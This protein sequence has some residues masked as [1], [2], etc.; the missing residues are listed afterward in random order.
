MNENPQ[1]GSDPNIHFNLGVDQL[2]SDS[3]ITDMHD[4]WLATAGQTPI[5]HVEASVHMPEGDFGALRDPRQLPG[6]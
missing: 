4:P 5:E 3:E 2:A 6:V 1:I